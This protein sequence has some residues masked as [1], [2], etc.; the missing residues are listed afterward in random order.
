L[1]DPETG[2]FISGNEYQKK[3]A[4]QQADI[5]AFNDD[6]LRLS[7]EARN[8]PMDVLM[9]ERRE[10][11]YAMEG[12]KRLYEKSRVE[13]GANPTRLS[14]PMSGV[15]SVQSLFGGEDPDTSEFAARKEDYV[16]A[17]KRFLALNR[18]VALNQDPAEVE[19]GFGDIVSRFGEGLG[20]DKTFD[21]RDYVEKLTEVFKENGIELTEGQKER[22]RMSF[23]EELAQGAGATTKIGIELAVN[24]IIANKAK[25]LLNIPKYVRAF[26]AMMGTRY[27]RAGRL[28]SKVLVN[29]GTNI[30]QGLLFEVSGG[31]FATGVG[32]SL[33]EGAFTKMV[34]LITKGKG[35]KLLNRWSRIIGGTGGEIVGEYVGDFTSNLN[36]LGIDNIEEVMDR[37]FGADM[38]EASRKLLLTS[39]LVLPLTGSVEVARAFKPKVDQAAAEYPDNESAQ[40]AKEMIDD[41]IDGKA[42]ELTKP[43]KEIEKGEDIIEE[44]V[45]ETPA[46]ETPV[47]ETAAA[48]TLEK[49]ELANNLQAEIDAIEKRRE[50]ESSDTGRL[51]LIQSVNNAKSDRDT[52]PNSVFKGWTDEEIEAEYKKGLSSIN[53]F[54]KIARSKGMDNE[55]ISKAVITRINNNPV[56]R[57]SKGGSQ[58]FSESIEKGV[59]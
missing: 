14:D 53:E 3:D 33:G 35:G 44:E 51:R 12:A 20:F 25:A 21:D 54:I 5:T 59:E 47:A 6:V 11:Y 52:D 46:A 29:A 26:Q 13:L 1:F 37:T 22:V 10:A 50:E 45:A 19:R 7:E 18:A 30:E 58:Q 48:E 36:E 32:E 28:V 40:E 41:V 34:D 27:G 16:E 31:N 56:L 38:D 42:K 49:A 17:Q 23:G 43:V 57:F 9:D 15:R 39:M 55:K 4:T 24:A 2:Q 8:T